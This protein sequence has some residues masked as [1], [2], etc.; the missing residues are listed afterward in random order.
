MSEL[1]VRKRKR[2]REKELRALSEEI[3]SKVGVQVFT[4][5]DTVDQAESSDMYL[6][7]VNGEIDAFIIQGQAFLTV[8]GLLKYPATRSFVTVDMGAIRFVIN[9]ADIMGPGIVEADEG[10]RPGDMV[11]IRDERNRKP[12]AVGQALVTG[13][14]MASKK[15]GKAIKSLLFV[16]DKLWKLEED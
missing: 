8:R 14:E 2:L 6:V 1:R 10:I 13:A 15:P 5:E 16:G 11:W 12:L 9:G 4:L 3:S 7:F